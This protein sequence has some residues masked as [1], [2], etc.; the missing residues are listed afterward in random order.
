MKVLQINNYHFIK[1]GSET[2]YLKTGELLE[3]RGHDVVYFSSLVGID[4][5]NLLYKSNVYLTKGNDF[6]KSVRKKVSS[7]ISYFYSKRS[8]KDLKALLRKEKPDIAHL[9][10]FYGNLSSSILKALK[11][12][13]I[14]IVMSVHEYR[15]L[16][17]VSVLYNKN[18]NICEKCAGGNYIPCV[19]YKCK[20]DS[21][22]QSFIQA[23]E[24]KF[25]DEY[26]DYKNFI[27]HFIMVSEFIYNKHIQYYPQLRDKSS[28]LYNFQCIDFQKVNSF[29][30]KKVDL[31]YFGRLSKEKG[32][33]TL[34]N[35]IR[36]MKDVSLRI[37]GDGPEYENIK[38]LINK[39]DLNIRVKLI[40]YS[41][42]E[43][44]WNYISEAK[45]VVV[46]SEWYEN[47]PMTVI[48]SQLM[49]IPVI[50]SKIGGIPEIIQNG[51]GFLF[52]AGSEEDLM[53]K[54]YLALGME[55]NEYNKMTKRVRDFAN[56]VFSE[57][58]HYE[59]LLNIYTDVQ[60]NYNLNIEN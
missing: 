39:N 9:H 28:K 45:F 54:I 33:I 49:G 20:N 56:S 38:E 24:A 35:A 52:K 15:M 18:G 53:D 27:D 37:I 10:I 44:L 41:S 2:V 21:Y 22:L 48:E 60:K 13:S 57:D 36:N 59:S 58:K 32:I 12:E 34:I 16:C 19:K 29:L 1:G 5:D 11:E 7:I 30:N 55:E 17:P 47:N 6:K 50:G 40:G 4:K 31:V 26:F 8:Y 46:P 23:L 14:P 42:G 3:K 43:E 51:Q 25:R